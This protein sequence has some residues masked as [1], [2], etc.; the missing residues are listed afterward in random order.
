[1]IQFCVPSGET[2][3]P[4][5]PGPNA[6]PLVLDVNTGDDDFDQSFAFKGSPLSFNDNKPKQ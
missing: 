1:M 3:N 5:W 2:K 4:L 6:P